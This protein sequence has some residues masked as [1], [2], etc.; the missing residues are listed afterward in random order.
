VRAR[1]IGMIGVMTLAMAGTVSAS[2]A[3]A[4]MRFAISF[5]SSLRNAVADGRAYVVVS[6]KSTPDPREQ[7]DVV[8]GVPFWGRDAD[9]VAPDRPVIVDS[10]P[11]T[12]GYPLRKLD[13]L[14]PGRYSVQAFFNVY[15]TFHRGDGS[16]VKMHMPCGDG[17]DLFNSPGNMYS[18]PQEMTL[19]PRRPGTIKISLNHLITPADPVPPGGTCQQ[20]NPPDTAHVKHIKILSPSLTKFWGTPMYIGANVLLPAGYDTNTGTHY[21]VEFHFA[22]FTEAAPHGFEENG[23]NAFSRWWLSSQAPRF[24]SVEVREENPFYDSSYVVD[25]ANVGPYGTATTKE[26]IPALDASFRTIAAPWGRIT[27]GGSTGGW[28]ALAGQIFY[29]GVYGGTFAGYPDPVDFHRHQIVNVYGDANAYDTFT[30]WDRI[31]K[32][33]SRSVYG[34]LQYT[35]AQENL[36]ELARGDH[37]RSG[38]AWAIWEAVYGPEGS[39]GYPAPVWNKRTGAIDSAV[40]ARW[41]PMDLDAKLT[42]EWAT[43][44]P[45]LQGKLHLYVGDMDTYYLNDAVELLQR[46]LSA[47]TNPPAAATF[48]FGRE[49]PHGWSPY[50]TRQWFQI[51]ADYIARHTPGKIATSAPRN[52]LKTMV[53]NDSGGVVEAPEHQVGLPR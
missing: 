39:D 18:T 38:G 50:T 5:P 19:S 28:E 26:L 8:G 40:A 31:P 32:P 14:P 10:G 53:S 24:I 35:M 52:P 23:G 12:Y 48:V 42:G 51:Y 20:G 49:K 7:I 46:N 16:T 36:W 6:R 30:E 3:T 44:G 47:E 34:D 27:S 13:T 29:P 43:L 22:H 1:L 41:K 9:H 11:Q 2:S 21:P 33:D 45:K 17:Q 25:S 15:T 4:P 37:D